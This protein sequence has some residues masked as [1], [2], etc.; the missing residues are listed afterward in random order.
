MIQVDW[1]APARVRVLSTT[2]QGGVSTGA[3][4]LVSGLS[5]GL[6]LGLHLGDNA[7]HY[8][9]NR[10]RVRDR[11]GRP[12]LWMDQ[13]HATHVLDADAIDLQA[14]TEV[15]VADAAICTSTDRALCIMTADCLP[16]LFSDPQGCCVGAAHAGWRGL[17]GGVL[18]NTVSAL[19]ARIGASVELL[20]WFGPA[21]G[22]QAFEVG[23]E[24]R[25]AFVERDPAADQAFRPAGARGK[26]LADLEHLARQRL[27]ECGAVS[28][29]GGGLCTV[30]DPA[31]F[32]SHR[33]DRVSGRMASL[34]WLAD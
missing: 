18:E 33:R 32:Y 28:V 24:V 13:V 1:P 31:R 3:W 29:Y 7:G 34:I 25:Q 20:A 17:L 4:G 15:P 5:G 12:I 6:N 14:A 2:R 10:A 9:V 26:W 30:G 11:V 27:A 8:E 23:E 16:V 19:R 21:I 22:P